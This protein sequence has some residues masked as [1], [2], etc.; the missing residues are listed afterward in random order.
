METTILDSQNP[1]KR[2][3]THA[4]NIELVEALVE[5]HHEKEGNPE[6]KFKPEYLKILEGKIS[7][8]LPNTG[9][10][11][12]PHIKSRL[13]TLKKEFQ[14]IHEM[15]TGPN[16]SG[17]GWDTVRK[18]IT[19]ENDVWDAYVQSRKGAAAYL[20]IVYA[21]DHDT[22]KDSQAPA[23]VVEELEAEK[24]DDKLDDIHEDVDCTQISTPSSN[25]KEQNAR[26]KKRRIQS[27]EDNMTEAMNEVTMILAAQLKDASNNLSKAVIGV[28][29]AESR[30]KIN[31]ELLKLPSLTNK[32]HHKATKLIDCQ[33][34]L[35]DVFL[36]MLDVEKEE[37][38]KGLI[39]GDF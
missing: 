28:V 26:K 5:Y 37:W 13:R 27:G 2:K 20:C 25:G 21:K 39:N 4:K 19:A 36:S 22:G 3:W 8:K 6:N 30:S 33:H 15:L 34:E 35:I 31:K 17:F 18:C 7:T 24:N 9:L 1:S 14:I 29:A 10:R 23:Y 38:V 32:E 12:K 16:T 11:A